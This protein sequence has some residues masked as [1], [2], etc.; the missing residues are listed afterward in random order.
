M[1]AIIV[2]RSSSNRV[3]VRVRSALAYPHRV[4]CIAV[5]WGDVQVHAL[6]FSVADPKTPP[7]T[8][9]HWLFLFDHGSFFLY[10]LAKFAQYAAALDANAINCFVS[11]DSSCIMSWIT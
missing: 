7:R 2:A 11:F 9:P 4:P 10:G 6:G 1:P 8:L 5:T 3:R